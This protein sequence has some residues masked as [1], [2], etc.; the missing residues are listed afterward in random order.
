[1]ACIKQI[2]IEDHSLL[3]NRENNQDVGKEESKHQET[4]S[5]KS[6][7]DSSDESQKAKRNKD[8][9]IFYQGYKKCK[10]HDLF[11][12]IYQDYPMTAQ[13]ALQEKFKDLLTTYKRKVAKIDG[14]AH[15]IHR[16]NQR[17]TAD[18]NSK[19]NARRYEA[20]RK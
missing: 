2:V 17:N 3:P 14:L 16:I 5:Y 1:M 9:K 6:E 8:P 15:R 19:E 10:E 20:M 11:S 18:E 7:A 12:L 4:I 13:K